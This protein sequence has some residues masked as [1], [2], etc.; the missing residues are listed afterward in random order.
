MP[1]TSFVEGLGEALEVEYCG[2]YD[3]AEFSSRDMCCLCDSEETSAYPLRWT[4]C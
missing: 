4:A 3:N 2:V 1:G